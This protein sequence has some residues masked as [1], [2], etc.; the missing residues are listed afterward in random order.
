MTRKPAIDE[1]LSA[2]PKLWKG[3]QFSQGQPTVPTG[4]ARLDAR[5][6]GGGWPLG[7]VTELLCGNPGWA[8]SACCSL[9][10]RPWA[11]KGSGSS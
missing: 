7:A 4:H 8:S 3:R 5:L 9:P 2:T 1:L 11:S 10:W 6:P